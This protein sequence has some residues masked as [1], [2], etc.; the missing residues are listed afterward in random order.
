MTAVE[1]MER[2]ERILRREAEMA[3]EN[4]ADALEEGRRGILD[5]QRPMQDGMG[6]P[7]MVGGEAMILSSN[8]ARINSLGEIWMR[9]EQRLA[10]IV[11]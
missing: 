10:Q 1:S 6:I 4:L 2:T 7:T 11:G 8:A 9:A 3:K 5:A